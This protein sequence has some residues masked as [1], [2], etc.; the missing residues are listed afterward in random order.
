MDDKQAQSLIEH[1]NAVLSA[2][3][4]RE[5]ID[6]YDMYR[7]LRDVLRNEGAQGFKGYLDAIVSRAEEFGRSRDPYKKVHDI[8]FGD[9]SEVPPMLE[10]YP[11]LCAW[12]LT[13]GR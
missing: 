12:R 1:L 7:E 8:I 6:S 4:T 2:P 11:T 5:T 13:L 10:K 9:P 3:F